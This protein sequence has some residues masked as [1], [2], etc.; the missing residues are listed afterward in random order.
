MVN[1]K[2]EIRI[3]DEIA[4]AMLA[5]LAKSLNSLGNSV[6]EKRQKTEYSSAMRDILDS[7]DE[8]SA[9]TGRFLPYADLVN[10]ISEKDLAQ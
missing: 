3:D 7:V 5:G 1:F 4:L 6:Y 10:Y 9:I 8:N 2:L